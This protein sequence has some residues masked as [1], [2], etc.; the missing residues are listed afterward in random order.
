MSEEYLLYGTLSSGTKADGLLTVCKLDTSTP[1]RTFKQNGSFCNRIAVL[2]ASILSAQSDRPII[3]SYSITKEAPMQKLILQEKL[4]CIVASHS[5]KFLAAG[6]H[7]GKLIIWELGSGA[8]LIYK[9]IHFGSISCLVFSQD[10]SV[11][12]SA[13]S[14]ARIYSWR[15]VELYNAHLNYNDVQPLASANQ[16]S[17]EVTGLYCGY[18]G[19]LDSRLYSIS[20]DGS[21]RVW[22]ASDLRLQT[23]FIF[24]E[25]L[26]SIVVDPAERAIYTGS[27]DGIIYHVD[28]YR[29]PREGAGLE[30]TGGLQRIVEVSTESNAKFT[31]HTGKVLSLDLSFDGTLL[32]SGSEDGTVIVWDI[33]THQVLKNIK[34]GRGPVYLAK[35]L[36]TLPSEHYIRH[37]SLRFSYDASYASNHDV[38]LD[39][40]ESDEFNVAFSI[41]NV[42]HFNSEAITVADDGEAISA[43]N[44]GSNEKE[45]LRAKVEKLSAAYNALWETYSTTVGLTENGDHEDLVE[46]AK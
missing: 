9:D 21:C 45:D 28:L 22:N 40:P 20:L 16:H 7:T 1:I 29:Q 11:L 23:T 25:A 39:I 8:C 36:E 34:P 26:L 14:D 17:L 38:W 12:F 44:Y 42:T 6:T 35:V 30:Y 37:E 41:S 27:D 33:A 19:I 13:G 43:I 3:H 10:D 18:G 4:A 2:D 15:T 24:K 46:A 32:V 31:Q 5:R